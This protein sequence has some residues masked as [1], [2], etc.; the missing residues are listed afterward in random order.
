MPSG[1]GFA[2]DGKPVAPADTVLAR[3]TLDRSGPDGLTVS[4]ARALP[5]L[6]HAGLLHHRDTAAPQVFVSPATVIAGRRVALRYE[7]SDDSGRASVHLQVAN[8]HG[9]IARFDIPLRAVSQTASY[10]L[11]WRAPVKLAHSVAAFCVRATDA[12]G[13]RSRTSCAKV[14]IK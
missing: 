5:A 2:V 11:V 1:F 9:V 3:Q 8:A 12:A 14:T 4:A 6:E 7:A 13:N 10:R